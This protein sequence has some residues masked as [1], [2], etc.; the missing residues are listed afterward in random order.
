MTFDPNKPVQTRDGR[1]ARIVCTDKKSEHPI[2][3]LIIEKDGFEAVRSYLE[4]GSYDGVTKD[5][6]L[7]LINVPE[8]IV[9]YLNAYP[10]GESYSYKSRKEA[11]VGATSFRMACFRVEFTEGQFDD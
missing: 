9:R 1:P 10:S 5:G 7:D 4:N 8:K 2:V 11:D 6:R 3:A